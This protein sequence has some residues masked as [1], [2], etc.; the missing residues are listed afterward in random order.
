M[1][2]KWLLLGVFLVINT[3]SAQTL[4]VATFNVS[5]EAGNYL[6]NETTPTGNELFALLAKG[7]NQ[8][9]RN[10]AAIIQNVRPDIILLNEFDYTANDE[11]GVKAF[12]NHYLKVAQK[13]AKAI[14]YPY[15]YTAPVN[16]GLDSGFDLNNDGVA[17]GTGD[18]AFGFGLYPGQYGMAILSRFPID[19]NAIRTFQ[20]FLWKD[21]PNNL[22]TTIKDAHG[23]DWF[24]EQAQQALR[25]SSKSHWDVPVLVNGETL[26]ILAS[27]PTPP[28][29]DGPEN[30]NGKRNHDEVRFWNDYLNSSVSSYIYDDKGNYGGLKLP[31]RFVILGDLNSSAI[32]GDSMKEAI[33]ALV[34]SPLVIQVTPLSAGGRLHKP[35]EQSASSFTA[36]WGM[37]ADYVLPSKYATKLIDCGVFWPTADSTLAS[38]VTD[39]QASSDHRLVWVDIGFENRK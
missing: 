10:I 34:Y 11:Q 12:I 21:M 31:S 5:M 13:N 9:I 2:R 17:S 37:R 7:E 30:R 32:N 1:K 19:K 20:H 15:Y 26:H 16:T 39:R 28:V 23:Q 6:T 38:L 25:L 24:S 18:D 3:S 36:E 35:N 8:Q 4:R 14:N 29:F 22:M 27:H 33:T